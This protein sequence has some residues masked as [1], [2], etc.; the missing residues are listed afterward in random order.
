MKCPRCDSQRIVKYGKTNY[1][2]QRYK[3]RS[4]QRQ[5]VE[6]PRHQP[7]SAQ[8]KE[9]IDK[10][11]LEKLPLAGIA[12]VTGVSK[13]WIQYYVNQK[14]YQVEKQAKISEKKR[15]KLIL[16]LDELWSY[17]GNKRQKAWIWLAQDS[18]TKEIINLEIGDRSHRYWR[19][20]IASTGDCLPQ[21]KNCQKILGK[22]S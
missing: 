2:K 7:I 8:Q 11:L 6:N 15:G 18:Q 4:C 3:C 14:Y 20:K 19:F 21:Y 5:F 12:R 1:G 9:L 16:Q 22:F 17:V 13:R 10:L